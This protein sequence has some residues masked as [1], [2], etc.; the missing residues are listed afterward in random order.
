MG[1]IFSNLI[2]VTIIIAILIIIGVILFLVR[3]LRKVEPGKALIIITPFRGMRVSFTGSLVIPFFHRMEIMDITTKMITV[4]R[5]GSDGLI[6]K[7]NIR[8]DISVKFYLRVNP[9]RDDVTEVARAI[10]VD[11]ASTAETLDNL[12]NSKFAEA[13]KT[14]GKQMEF[15]ELFQ[16]RTL[17]KEEIIKT[18]GENLNGYKLEDTAIDYLEQTP[19]AKLDDQNVMDAEGI[20]KI[21]EITLTKK[22]VVEKR[23]TETKERVLELEKLR[24]EAELK[25]KAEIQII[26]SKEEATAMTIAEEERLKAES[27]RIATD[28]ALE[29]AAVN[30]ERQI[31]VANLNKD[32]Q[33][34]VESERVERDRSLEAT[35][36]QKLVALADIEKEKV[37]EQERKNI[38]DII[39]QRV[40]VERTVAEEEEATNNTRA[41]AAADRDKQVAITQAEQEAEA[42]LIVSIKE[43]EAREKAA[44][45]LAQEKEINAK[46]ELETS[47]KIAESKAI[48]A[49]GIIEE[50]SAPDIAKVKVKEA[51]AEAI[52]QVGKAEADALR[53]KAEA[54]AEAIRKTGQ[55]EAD[56]LQSKAEANA[57]AI[58]EKG[59]AEAEIQ[60]V[61]ATAEA[62]MIKDKGL[63]EVEVQTANADATERVGEAEAAAL[64]FKAEVE[65]DAIQKKADAMKNYDEVGREHEEFKLKLE[66]EERLQMQHINLQKDMVLAR[67]DVLAAA[68]KSAKI[69]IVGG[70]SVFFDKITDSI[71]DGKVATAYLQN[72]EL[73]SDVKSALLTPNGDVADR[74]KKLIQEIGV[75]SET[76]KNLS[77]ANALAK[78]TSSSKDQG[79]LEKLGNLKQMAE[80]AGLSD[81]TIKKLLG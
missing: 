49:K 74:L 15:E 40:A 60:Q 9:T 20:R 11:R 10:G 42:Q 1:N 71:T 51:N 66:V 45:H 41:F 13:L 55:A 43:A 14:V 61:Q 65:A 62:Q 26:G 8:A 52:R 63:A 23:T 47:A 39:R 24:V 22:E 30:K 70:D 29:V 73:L 69:D 31:E 57:K 34:A 58:K 53:F 48:L 68:L 37:V 18:I 75:N 76:I 19:L 5:N 12:F 33:V 81:M 32:R 4:E 16:E 64:R 27:S 25:Q 44:M 50:Q 78:L 72:N 54:D 21:T 46:V 36:R 6:C 77:V 80:K 56:A 2:I 35:E 7:D 17:F 59:T 3:F 38:Q 67:A 28:E 79:L